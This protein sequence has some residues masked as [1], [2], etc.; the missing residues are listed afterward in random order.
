VCLM[1]AENMSKLERLNK[2]RE[3]LA[4]VPSCGFCSAGLRANVR[5]LQICSRTSLMHLLRLFAG[6]EAAGD[7]AAAGYGKRACRVP[8][9][10]VQRQH[11]PYAALSPPARGTSV[12]HLISLLALPVF[13][14][15]ACPRGHGHGMALSRAPT[16]ARESVAPKCQPSTCLHSL[17]RVRG[18]HPPAGG[19]TGMTASRPPLRTKAAAASTQRVSKLLKDQIRSNYNTIQLLFNRNDT[20]N[21]GKVDSRELLNVMARCNVPM[22]EHQ[23][24]EI[25]ALLD[26]D[27]H[28]RSAMLITDPVNFY[29]SSCA[30]LPCPSPGFRPAP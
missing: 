4:S 17:A 6:R 29:R 12:A 23:A 1:T 18:T 25:V 8:E 13:L 20:Q 14:C 16:G 11:S 27:D 3:V 30:S 22:T 9:A 2:L 28:G 15:M 19:K 21:T 24:G 5:L 26:P 10:A 7:G